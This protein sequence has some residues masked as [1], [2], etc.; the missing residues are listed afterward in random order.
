MLDLVGNSEDSFSHN[1]AHI[2]CPKFQYKCVLASYLEIPKDIF[3]LCGS[4]VNVRIKTYFFKGGG[5]Q[6]QTRVGQT[7]FHNLKTHTLENQGWGVRN[8]G[9]FLGSAHGYGIR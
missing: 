7:Y 4:V 6:L 5:V 9:P 3:S 1:E 2:S 8:T